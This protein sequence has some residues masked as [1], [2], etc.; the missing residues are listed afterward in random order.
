M[1]KPS[2]ADRAG[3]TTASSNADRCPPV[4]LSK[5]R[6]LDLVETV[7]LPISQKIRNVQ[8]FHH[9]F[10]D[11]E[12]YLKHTVKVGQLALAMLYAPHKARE[13]MERMEAKH[14]EHQVPMDILEPLITEFFQ[15]YVAWCRMSKLVPDTQRDQL[16]N[17]INGYLEQWREAYPDSLEDARKHEA[18]VAEESDDGFMMFD[19]ETGPEEEEGFTFFE[20]EE[21]DAAIDDMH[22]SAAD[23][24]VISAKDYMATGELEQSQVDIIMD[25]FRE[26]EAVF[27]EHIRFDESF[28]QDYRTHLKYLAETLFSTYEFEQMGYNLQQLLRLLDHAS[29]LDEGQQ[30]LIF[31]L[32]EQLVLDL[33]TWAKKLFVEQDA[34]DIHYL[35]AAL[36]AAIAQIEMMLNIK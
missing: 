1:V 34:I 11:R 30:V 32:L 13:L 12:D 7:I 31:A 29:E 3:K 9:Y 6:A 2:V 27:A 35:D 5:K 8:Q 4:P 24:T 17:E 19:Q 18:P 36:L 22:T 26:L 25:E 16:E 28:I 14:A 20:P 10:S 21:V 15:R 23:K 33:S